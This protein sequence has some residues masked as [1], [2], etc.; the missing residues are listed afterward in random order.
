[1]FHVITFLITVLLF[2]GTLPVSI[3]DQHFGQT[4]AMV[5]ATSDAKIYNATAWSTCGVLAA[6][7]SA[8]L[9]LGTC[10]IN[11]DIGVSI[12]AGR[13]P[14]AVCLSILPAAVTLSPAY[15]KISPPTERLIGKPPEYVSA[16]VETYTRLVKHKRQKYAITGTVVGCLVTGG[17]V[18]GFYANWSP[19]PL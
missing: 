2:L 19:W 13:I 5:D 8:C 1:M 14:L 11:P 7:T 9:F 12:I 3:A 6:P 18:I 10:I 15:V 17:A 16:Y 4:Q